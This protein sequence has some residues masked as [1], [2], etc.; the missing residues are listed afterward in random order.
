MTSKEKGEVISFL[1]EHLGRLNNILKRE[2]EIFR[3]KRIGS[4]TMFLFFNN[5]RQKHYEDAVVRIGRRIERLLQQIEECTQIIKKG[6]NKAIQTYLSKLAKQTS[7][8]EDPILSKINSLQA[9]L[10]K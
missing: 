9:L 7:I 10:V 2:R 8:F 1:E 4:H 5:A 3:Q 6:E